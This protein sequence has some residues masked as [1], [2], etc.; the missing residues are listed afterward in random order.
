MS[1]TETW[2]VFTDANNPRTLARHRLDEYGSLV[3]GIYRRPVRE[4][5]AHEMER[6]RPCGRCVPAEHDGPPDAAEAA[7]AAIREA[8]G[9]VARAAI[10]LGEMGY[11]RMESALAVVAER[12][13]RSS[14]RAEFES[15]DDA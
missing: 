3:C 14:D 12:L 9:A 5:E 8:A 4:L 2:I 13:Y 10:T 6:H 7:A 15:E 1:T 11:F